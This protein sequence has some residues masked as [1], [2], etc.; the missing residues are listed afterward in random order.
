MSNHEPAV[1]GAVEGGRRATGE[2]PK[3][4]RRD[5]GQRAAKHKMTVALELLRGEDLASLNR[6]Y[7]VTTALLSERQ[8]SVL[9]AGEVGLKIRDEGLVD[10]QGR[11]MKSVIAELAMTVELQRERIQQLGN[12]TPSL[13]WRSKR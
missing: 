6:K 13:R 9:A 3:T 8:E 12:A 10:E 2:A 4:G 5:K 7:T 11:Q 1:S